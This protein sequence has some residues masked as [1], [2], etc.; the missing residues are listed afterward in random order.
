MGVLISSVKPRE[1]D[2]SCEHQKW[3]QDPYRFTHIYDDLNESFYLNED[4][5]ELESKEYTNRWN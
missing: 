1:S 5:L 2:T 4:L 3:A